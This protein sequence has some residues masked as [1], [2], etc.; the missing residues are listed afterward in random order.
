MT[1]LTIVPQRPLPAGTSITVTVNGVQDPSGNAVP[2]TTSSFTTGTTP[3][4]T[5]PVALVANIAYGDTNVPVNTIFEW[6][7]SEPI[8]ATTVVGQQNVLYDYVAGAYIQ[9]ATLS[10]SADGRRVTFAASCKPAR[11]T[12]AFRRARQRRR[13]GRQLRRRDFPDLHDLVGAG[14][15]AATGR[16][17]DARQRAHDRPAQRAR[18][19]RFR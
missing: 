5:P 19:N 13:S 12:S 1:S 9:G 15:D 18:A 14:H 3:D 4:I 16:D 8:D 7:Y 10:V 11:R 6:T 2:L 17:R